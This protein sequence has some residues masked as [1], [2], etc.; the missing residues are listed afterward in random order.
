MRSPAWH[1]PCYTLFCRSDE[2]M[3]PLALES[4]LMWLHS[5]QVQDPTSEKKFNSSFLTLQKVSNHDLYSVGLHLKNSS[6]SQF[7]PKN[8][9]LI[10]FFKTQGQDCSTFCFSKQYTEF[11]SCLNEFGYNKAQDPAKKK[12][13]HQL[14]SSSFVLQRET[15]SI[16]S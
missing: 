7:S 5:E 14:N 6:K 15:V 11:D 16:K 2:P 4:G 3:S 8:S 10:F 12:K 1:I 13:F 9:G